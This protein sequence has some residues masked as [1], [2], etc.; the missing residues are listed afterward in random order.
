[1]K[2]EKVKTYKTIKTKKLDAP[3]FSGKLRDYPSF[4]K[5]YERHMKP[6]YGD[7][8][9][10]LRVCLTGDAELTIKGVE[11][12]YRK[13]FERL[14]DKYGCPEKLVDSIMG[15]LKAL[16]KIQEGDMIDL[17][18]MIEIVERSWLDLNRMNMSAEMN[19]KMMISHVEKL[20]PDLQRREWAI[21]RQSTK[22]MMSDGKFSE[23]L[24][25]LLREKT[26]IEYMSCN[27][28]DG[29]NSNN[30]K[31]RV[32]TAEHNIQ[33]GEDKLVKELSDMQTSMK[34]V[35]E[36]LAQVSQAMSTAASIS[37]TNHILYNLNMEIE[38]GKGETG[39]P[40]NIVGCIQLKDMALRIVC[41]S[42]PWMFQQD[43]KRPEKTL[44]AFVA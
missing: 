2:V 32:H 36:G 31:G 20:L 27:I 3:H 12:D 35:I 13:M 40:I 23:M 44:Y 4:K 24:A 11:D 7:D 21:Y 14:D 38:H 19:T 17:V 30:S 33:E 6:V 25:F 16:K 18:K 41:Y 8:P 15:D 5:N 42:N 37:Y 26:A 9:Y 39:I 29:N 28:R 43:W 22:S 10:A 1:M 34:L